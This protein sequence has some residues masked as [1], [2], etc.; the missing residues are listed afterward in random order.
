MEQLRDAKGRFM[1]NKSIFQDNDNP[2]GIKDFSTPSDYEDFIDEGIN[3]DMEQLDENMFKEMDNPF[4][5]TL[6]KATSA[7]IT[8]INLEG[9]GTVFGGPYKLKPIGMKGIKLAPEI[10]LPADYTVDIKDFSAPT[11]DQMDKAILMGLKFL[12]SDGAFYVGCMF[13]QG[14]TGTYIACLL[15]VF[16]YQTPISEARA[17]YNPKA[18]ETTQQELFVKDY[19]VEKF[20]YL[21][22]F[23]LKN[24]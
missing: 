18:V 8:G 5:D 20:E 14:R 24:Q 12:Q 17:L 15:K 1:G 13:G 16:G 11:T 10:E 4:N 21:V 19:P 3:V 23:M 6:A 7:T 9:F 2:V 22:R